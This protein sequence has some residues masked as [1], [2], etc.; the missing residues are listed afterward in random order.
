[1]SINFNLGYI[2][3]FGKEHLEEIVA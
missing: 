3:S 1:M 2:F